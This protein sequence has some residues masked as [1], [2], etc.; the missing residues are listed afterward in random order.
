M[1]KYGRP[2]LVVPPSSTRAMFGWSIRASAC[3]SASKRAMTCRESMP[4]LIS[5]TATRRLTGSVCWA[6]Q[7]LPMPPSPIG[8][9]SL[10]GPITVPGLSV[11]GWSMVASGV[12]A[13]GR[14]SRLSGPSAAASSAST[15]AIRASSPP[16]AS[17]T[18]SRRRSGS[19]M[20]PGGV[21]DRLVVGP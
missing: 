20:S 12:P 1:T 5:L 18:Y 7:T 14:S 3:R 16:H 17:R 21:E 15:W 19:G 4:A 11:V 6:I 10:Y 13:A 9:M 2:P 8:S